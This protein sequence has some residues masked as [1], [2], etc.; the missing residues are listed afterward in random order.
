[1]GIREWTEFE[2]IRHL[3][4][5]TVSCCV[6]LLLALPPALLVFLAGRWGMLPPRIVTA[7]EWVEYVYLLLVLAIFAVGTI[8]SI[9]RG[10]FDGSN[11]CIFA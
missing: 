3:V 6:C 4:K 2:T 1:M 7:V 8:T 9:G 5:H 11:R 10:M